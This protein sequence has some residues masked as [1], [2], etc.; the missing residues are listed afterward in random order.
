MYLFL[1]ID[2]SIEINYE[3]HSFFLFNLTSYYYDTEFAFYNYIFY[4][5]V[6]MYVSK[7]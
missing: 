3:I 2:V 6:V 7:L 4:F 1:L 5:N